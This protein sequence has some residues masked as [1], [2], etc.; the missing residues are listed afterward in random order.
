MFCAIA[1]GLTTRRLAGR[2]STCGLGWLHP[3]LAGGCTETSPPLANSVAFVF[4]ACLICEDRR[5]NSSPPSR[6]A[7]RSWRRASVLT[8]TG[9]PSCCASRP[10]GPARVVV[11]RPDR[12]DALRLVLVAPSGRGHF[13][14]G[15][16]RR[17]L[18]RG[19]RDG[20]AIPCYPL[21]AIARAAGAHFAREAAFAPRSDCDLRR[22]RTLRPTRSCSSLGVLPEYPRCRHPPA[23]TRPLRPGPRSG[24]ELSAPRVIARPHAVQHAKA[25][26]GMHPDV[27]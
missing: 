5:G 6:R 26:G 20:V 10:F 23:G 4:R 16:V 17:F 7:M 19:L 22:S 11:P 2:R 18:T 3:G 12:R 13:G 27:S 15:H 21:N 8:S 24:S 9:P 1:G 14:S 25:N